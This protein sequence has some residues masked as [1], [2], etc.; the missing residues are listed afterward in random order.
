MTN[1]KKIINVKKIVEVKKEELKLKIA[2]L[3]NNGINPK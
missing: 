2:K 3:K 1:D